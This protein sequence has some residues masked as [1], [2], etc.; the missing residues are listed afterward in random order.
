M[1]IGEFAQE[2]KQ[3]LVGC[4]IGAVVWLVGGA[5]VDSATAPGPLPRRQDTLREAYKS[6]ELGAAQEQNEQLE[7]ERARLTRALAFDVS[8][9]YKDWSGPADQHLFQRGNALRLTIVNSA[10][11]RDVLV[12]GDDITWDVPSGVDQIRSTLFGLD[13]ID[14]LQRRLFAAHDRVLAAD[15]DAM[16][17]SGIQSIKLQ[18]PRRRR[19]SGGFR[20]RRRGG[21]DVSA[22]LREQTVDVQLQCDE[23]TLAYFLESCR[24]RGRTLVLDRLTVT[25][26]A[27]PG[28]GATV[29]ATLSGISF[30]AEEE[31]K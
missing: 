13:V 1:D 29:K 7:A 11:D 5:I 20:G 28:E 8:A 22:Q 19:P 9:A 6:R 27:R 23:P 24:E 16:G 26:P 2:N 30:V 31:Q 17:L 15:E 10:S 12:E 3:W 18:S 21:P 4:A 14:E 25:E